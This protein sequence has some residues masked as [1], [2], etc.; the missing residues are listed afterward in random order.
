MK[1]IKFILFIVGTC[2]IAFV[3]IFLIKEFINI[4]IPFFAM[5][6]LSFMNIFYSLILLHALGEIKINR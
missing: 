4:E 3:N 5:L 2:F 6:F 1:L